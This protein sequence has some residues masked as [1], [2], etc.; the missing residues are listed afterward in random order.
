MCPDEYPILSPSEV[1]TYQKELHHKSQRNSL[2]ELYQAKPLNHK[3]VLSNLVLSLAD[4]M[5]VS[6]KQLKERYQLI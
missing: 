2:Q 5:I 4:L 6:G 3:P 1:L